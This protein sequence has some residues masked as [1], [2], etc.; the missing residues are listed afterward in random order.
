MNNYWITWKSRR[1][2]WGLNILFAAAVAATLSTTGM[3][4]LMLLIPAVFIDKKLYRDKRVVKL[5]IAACAAGVLAL[6]AIYLQGGVL[7]AQV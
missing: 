7:W 6:I 3:I 2:Y 5:V 4:E 1:T